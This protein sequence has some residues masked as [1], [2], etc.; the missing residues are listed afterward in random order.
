[1]LQERLESHCI[2]Q[3]GEYGDFEYLIPLNNTFTK[4]LKDPLR[5]KLWGKN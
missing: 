3:L 4:C 1:M 2:R 5:E